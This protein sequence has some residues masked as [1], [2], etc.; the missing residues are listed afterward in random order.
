MGTPA[1]IDATA[2]TRHANTPT[3][4][5][6]AA[7]A[8]RGGFTPFLAADFEDGTAGNSANGTDAFGIEGGGPFTNTKYS[9]TQAA[10]GS[11]SASMHCKVGNTGDSQWGARI[12]PTTEWTEG[13]EIWVRFKAYFHADFVHETSDSMKFVRI[14][15]RHSGTLANEGYADFYMSEDTDQPYAY[16]KE[17]TENVWSYSDNSDPIANS[18]WD[19]FEFYVNFDTLASDSG[20]T[21]HA[22]IWKNGKLLI[23]TPSKTLDSSSSEIEKIFF[24]SHWNGGAPLKLSSVTGTFDNT[25]TVTGVT[26]G[27]SDIP[28]SVENNDTLFLD[29]Q[30]G[31]QTWSSGETINQ[32]VSGASGTLD[33]DQ[34]ECYIDEVIV[35]VNT[36]TSKDAA[37]NSFIGPN[38]LVSE[39][40]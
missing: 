17:V 21:G 2:W 27:E 11:Q 8:D 1:N 34:Y 4:D 35:S 33:Y 28:Q 31:E 3:I 32:A 37:G 25:N 10:T 24:F 29:N 18:Q 40:E 9:A 39:A 20:G 13:T 30:V 16:I 23:D 7:T 19:T 14:H 5:G 22:R 12:Q 6:H 26:S 36:P 38:T 15:T